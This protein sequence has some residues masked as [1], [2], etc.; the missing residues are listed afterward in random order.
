MTSL[1]S[2][3]LPVDTSP[4][5]FGE[6]SDSTPLLG[7]AD[8]LRARIAQDGYLYLRGLL[9][10]DEVLA[11]RRS[12]LVRL[13]DEGHVDTSFPLDEARAAAGTTIAF[14]PDLAVGNPAVDK[15]VYDGPMMAFFTRLLGGPVRHFDF[16][17]VRA[18]A[19]WQATSPHMDVV[20]MGRGTHRLYTVWTPYGDVPRELGGLMVLEGS[21]RDRRL[22]DGYAAQDV[23]SY[24]ENIVGPGFTGMGGGGNIAEGG[25]LSRDPV[26]LRAE[27]GGR[28][29][30]TD[31]HMGDVLVFSIFLVHCSLD[32]TTD[33]IRLTSDTRYQLASEPAD[34]RWIGE[35][36]VGHG[37]NAKRSMIC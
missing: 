8:A 17:W 3:R 10:P 32:N 14:R 6:L 7:D 35:H 19:P 31:Y 4:A 21:H 23:D 16:T 28:W 24:C 34:E 9:D 26:A 1:T 20:Y 2:A 30:T 29:L 18:V 22:L 11:A 37:P 12:M 33:R 36:P 27:Q 13:A 25:Y 15:V 5:A